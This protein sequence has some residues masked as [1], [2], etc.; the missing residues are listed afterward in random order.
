M[1]LLRGVKRHPDGM[2]LTPFASLSFL[3]SG[4]MH[5]VLGIRIPSLFQQSRN[6]PGVFFHVLCLFAHPATGYFGWFCL[7]A[8]VTQTAENMGVLAPQTLPLL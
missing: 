6:L 5:A 7:L 1:S 4:T 8:S 2:C 3:S